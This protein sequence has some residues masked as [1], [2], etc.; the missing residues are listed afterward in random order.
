MKK[1]LTGIFL[2]IGVAVFA[3]PGTAPIKEMNGKRYYEH[4]VQEG[5]TLWGLQTM[6]GVPVEEIVAENPDLKNG[7]KAGQNVYIPVTA[8]SAQ[9]MPT[10][11]YKV[12]KGETLYGIS[13]KF[14][15]SID[16]LMLLNPEL[17]QGLKKGQEIKVPV[18]ETAVADPFETNTN[19]TDETDVS[20]VPNPFILD[21]IEKADGSLEE[22]SFKFSDSTIRH[23][24]MAHETMYSVSKRFMVSIEEIMKINGLTSS[25]IKEGQVLIIPVKQERI[26]RVEIKDVPSDYDPEGEGPVYFAEKESYN[27]VLMLPFY[28]GSSSKS[29]KRITDLATQFYMGVEL[30]VDSLEKAGLNLNLTVLDTKN[31]SATVVSL[32]SKPE[33]LSADMIIGPMFGKHV[34]VVAD[35]CKANKIRMVA[36]ATIDDAVVESN[37]LVYQAVP[38]SERLM[39][40]MAV[41]MLDHNATDHIVLVKP[42]KESD[43]PLYNAFKE[44]FETGR[45]DGVR[46]TYVEST[47]G[48]FTGQIKRGVK[49]IFVMPTN[50]RAT[51]MKFMNSLNRSAFRSSPKNLF[52]YGTKEWMNFDDISSMYK[53]KFNFHYASPNFLDYYKEDVVAMNK[54]YRKKYNTDL[55]RMAAHGYDV[56]TYFTNTLLGG[57]QNPHL[58]MSKFNMRQLSGKAGYVNDG[59]FMIEQEEYELIDIDNH[60]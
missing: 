2:L 38:S 1:L 15:V 41:Y 7:L 11:T 50:D 10:D 6:Y 49:T 8:E 47:L 43:M 22:V 40:Q 26:E 35:F 14:K 56:I 53:N 20:D 37:R 27:V 58:L 59:V 42:E 36:P 39:A 24:V 13:K 57:N 55:S 52:V 19:Q 48:T 46:V 31:D 3:Q 60:E 54:I 4:K 21:T 17:E 9:K 45:G 12:K 25:S 30:A 18:N 5:N 32:L 51:A 34:P 33:V 44:R 16:D 28:L 29:T 23:I